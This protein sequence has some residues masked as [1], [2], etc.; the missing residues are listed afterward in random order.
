MNE[1]LTFFEILIFLKRA[2]TNL[3]AN[4]DRVNTTLDGKK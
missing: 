3:A 2:V 1:D 4:I